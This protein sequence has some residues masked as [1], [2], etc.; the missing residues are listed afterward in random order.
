ML[1]TDSH[2]HLDRLDLS[3][4][5]GDLAA[6]VAAARERGV[7]R[8]LCIGIDR[9]NA[10]TV[11]EIARR[12]EGIYASVGIHPLDIADQVE[13]V[14]ELVALADDELVIAI[15]ETGLDYYY[16]QDKKSEQQESFYNH[17]RASA[18]TGK[19]SIVHTRDAREDTLAII[20]E[21]SDPNVAGVLHCF[22]ESLEMA[23]AALEM[24]FYISFSGIITFKNAADLREVVAHVPL[25]RMLIETDSPYLAPMPY[26][27]KKNEPKY[28]VEVAQ[29]VAG[30]KGISFEQVAEQ[31]AENFDRLFKLAA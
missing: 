11:I 8:M 15:G 30:I 27:G 12:F 23:K 29:C 28:V 13:A 1:L 20:R 7:A 22:T 19:P 14:D 21:A 16:T 2:C 18:Q 9:S 6:A 25:E 26:R 4:Y 24:N 3:P 31:T 5:D 10:P 17:L